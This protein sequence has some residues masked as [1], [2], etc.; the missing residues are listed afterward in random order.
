[1]DF[2]ARGS[3]AIETCDAPRGDAVRWLHFD[4]V[5]QGT[6]RWLT[7]RALLPPAV[8]DLM[9]Q[10]DTHQRA[11]VDGDVVALVLHDFERDFDVDDTARVGALRIALAPGLIVTG[12]QH[13]LVSFDVV[14]ARLARTGEGLGPGDALDL[15]VTAISERVAEL[16]RG[17]AGEILRAEEAFL[18]GYRPPDTRELIAI[19]RRLAQLHR[20]L[21]GMRGVFGRLEHADDMPDPLL[22]AVRKLSQQ[23]H[24][25]DADIL[26]S[27]NELRLLRD[28]LDAQATQR[29]NQNLYILSVVTAL[30]LPA[31]LVTGVFGMN[32]GGMPFA[33]GSWGTLHAVVIA[34]AGS[35]TTYALLRWRGFMR[36]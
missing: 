15:M 35:A 18:D 36:G 13:P 30:M 22:P 34:A 28:D 9:L 25:I 20:L 2:D 32:T 8:R 21:S 7:A 23:L 29:T 10:A 5:H 11:L 24:A 3:R 12:R 17:L 27:Q 19:R 14:R 33:G 16:A 31:T 4:L 1:M 26:A 6:H